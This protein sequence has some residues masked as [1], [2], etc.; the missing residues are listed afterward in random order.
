MPKLSDIPH[1]PDHTLPAL[2]ALLNR[3]K[4]ALAGRVSIYGT[5]NDYLRMPDEVPS[6]QICIPRRHLVRNRRN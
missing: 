6:G 3:D 4:A 1:A 2:S 5:A